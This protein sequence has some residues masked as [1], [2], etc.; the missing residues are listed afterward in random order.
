MLCLA[1]LMAPVAAAD[2]NAS[3]LEVASSV[4]DGESPFVWSDVDLSKLKTPVCVSVEEPPE[5]PNVQMSGE[6]GPT[7]VEFSASKDHIYVSVCFTVC[8]KVM[9][10]R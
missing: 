3:F 5:L 4:G 10:Y 7:T 9:V 6:C 1:T 8:V 2:A